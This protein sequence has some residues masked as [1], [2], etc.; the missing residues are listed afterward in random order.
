MQRFILIL[1]AA[2]LAGCSSMASLGI[3]GRSVEIRA[4][5]T[6]AAHCAGAERQAR[7]IALLV[8]VLHDLDALTDALRRE[9]ETVR[10]VEGIDV[11]SAPLDGQW[12]YKGDGTNWHF[13]SGPWEM[14]FEDEGEGT[15]HFSCNDP[16]RSAEASVK[17]ERVDGG[18]EFSAWSFEEW[19]ILTCGWTC[20]GEVEFVQPCYFEIPVGVEP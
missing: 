15:I 18:Y 4:T 20:L 2:L 13:T 3:Q 9:A 14:T 12:I 8:T 16:E 1:P 10:N 17:A 7:E 5:E 6:T 11:A 19:I